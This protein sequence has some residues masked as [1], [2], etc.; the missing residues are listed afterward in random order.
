[1]NLV[2][3]RETWRTRAI[4]RVPHGI[5]LLWIYLWNQASSNTRDRR[6]LQANTEENARVEAKNSGDQFGGEDSGGKGQTAQGLGLGEAPEPKDTSRSVRDGV[7][8]P[9]PVT[10]QLVR[11]GELT[12]ATAMEVEEY[13]RLYNELDDGEEQGEEGGAADQDAGPP[14]ERAPT[15]TGENKDG[16]GRARNGGPVASAGFALHR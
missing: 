12:K 11:S 14:S 7:A 16:D 15:G 1:M 4:I 9:D 10:G 6:D 13:L 8:G 2:S 3:I 5:P